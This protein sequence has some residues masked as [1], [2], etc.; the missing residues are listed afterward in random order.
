MLPSPHQ[1]RIRIRRALCHLGRQQGILYRR[2][3]D[4]YGGLLDTRTEIGRVAGYPYSKVRAMANIVIALPGQID[5]G[6]QA[7]D[8]LLVLY[9]TG[10]GCELGPYDYDPPAAQQ[11]DVLAMQ[12]G[13]EYRVIAAHDTYGGAYQIYQLGAM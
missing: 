2:D 11:D 7:S 4:Q 12:N 5:E 1:V 10:A 8:Y 9:A 6:S 13:K 3:C